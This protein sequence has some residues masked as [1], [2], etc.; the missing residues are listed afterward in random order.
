LTP[1]S[2]DGNRFNLFAAENVGVVPVKDSVNKMKDLE[3]WAKVSKQNTLNI[4]LPDIQIPFE[5]RTSFQTVKF[6]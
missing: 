6:F 1:F 5:Y 2:L 4:C 3:P